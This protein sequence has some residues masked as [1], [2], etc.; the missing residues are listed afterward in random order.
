MAAAMAEAAIAAK[1][2]ATILARLDPGI[3]LVV[4]KDLTFVIGFV[5]VAVAAIGV[6]E[7][8]LLLAKFV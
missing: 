7:T 8:I 3:V 6:V 1:D 4:E 2:V 5:D